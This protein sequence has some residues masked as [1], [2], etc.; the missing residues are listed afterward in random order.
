MQAQ[1]IPLSRVSIQDYNNQELTL[2]DSSFSSFAH[3]INGTEVFVSVLGNSFRLDNVFKAKD[4]VENDEATIAA[5]YLMLSHGKRRLVH[6]PG[7]SGSCRVDHLMFQ[8]H[9]MMST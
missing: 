3:F 5:W 9:M 6:D 1:V 7:M 8:A 4:L 2:Q